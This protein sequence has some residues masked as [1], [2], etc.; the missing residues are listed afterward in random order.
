MAELFSP[1]TYYF[2]SKN[3]PSTLI[4]ELLLKDLKVYIV[5]FCL[6]MNF[7]FFKNDY[8]LIN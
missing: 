6:D 5:E 1:I 7:S 4:S 2:L 8:E 3:L